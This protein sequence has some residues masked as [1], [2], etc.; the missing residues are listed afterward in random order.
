MKNKKFKLKYDNIFIVFS[1]LFLG[2]LFIFYSVRFIYFF[3]IEKK[4][5][6]TIA[7]ATFS[8]LLINNDKSLKKSGKKYYYSGKDVNNYVLY[9]GMMFR[10]VSIEDGY[11]KLVTDDVTTSLVMT[12]DQ[13]NYAKTYTNIWLN[14]IEGENTSGVF[15]N[16]LS[17][18]SKYLVNTKTCID[19]VSDYEK[20]NKC[21]NYNKDYLVGLLSIDEYMNSGANN[22]YLNNETYYWL[23]NINDSGN[24]WY[25]FDKGGL[26]DKSK[27]EVNYHV[28]GVRPTI[29]LNKDIYLISGDGSKEA[30]YVF[31]KNE[32]KLLINRNIGDYL[33]YGGYLWRVVD[34][35]NG[36]VGLAL[37]DALKENNEYLEKLYDLEG[38]SF[39]N[40]NYYNYLNQTFINTI[41]DKS[42]I[43]RSNW[44]D[45][46][47][48]ADS[49]FDYRNIYT[50]S[51]EANVGLLNIGDMYITDVDGAFLM[52]PS[53]KDM[54]Y[55]I[56]ENK[57]FIEKMS[58]KLKIRP[59]I[60]I[61]GKVNIIG[62][63][64]KEEPFEIEG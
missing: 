23:S 19:K 7:D 18:K 43:V 56:K 62:N 16:Y 55:S 22:G 15:S 60:F 36:N 37:A 41:K 63:G 40:S 2:M 54:V 1:I 52:T 8:E 20:V 12:Y 9:S 38:S 33:N 35:R 28:Y 26:S 27:T 6:K 21:Q 59:V 44:Y 34:F 30:P 3:S 64:T 31:E 13:D 46:A 50:H 53:S 32:N 24:Y 48:N 51:V 17:D 57:L 29:T 47:Y 5:P 45:G 10:I 14:E 11:I 25:V 58:T 4:K 49:K 39:Y 42:L 61:D